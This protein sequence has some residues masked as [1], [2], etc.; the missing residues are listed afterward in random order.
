MRK[1][2]LTVMALLAATALHAQNIIYVCASGLG[3][4]PYDTL[5]RAAATLSAAVDYAKGVYEET[6]V[7]PRI[8]IVGK[9]INYQ[10]TELSNVEIFGDGWDDANLSINKTSTSESGAATMKIGENVLLHGI[11]FTREGSVEIKGA[12][13]VLCPPPTP[14]CGLQSVT[15]LTE[16]SSFS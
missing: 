10:A 4:E 7:R 9:V 15:P 6:G 1:H 12:P 8:K 11:L 14:R 2:T 3:V 13:S 5:N 16:L